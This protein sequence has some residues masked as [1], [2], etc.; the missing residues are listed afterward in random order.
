MKELIQ[1]YRGFLGLDV[2]LKGYIDLDLCLKTAQKHSL[3]PILLE[4]TSKSESKDS[5]LELSKYMARHAMMLQEFR[6]ISDFLVE[7]NIESLFFKGVVLGA[8]IYSNPV[9]RPCRDIDVLIKPSDRKRVLQIF[10]EKGYVP[11]EAYSQSELK[12]ELFSQPALEFYHV[13]RKILVDIHWSIGRSLY[14]Q[15]LDTKELFS[16]SRE[17]ELYDRKV[18]TLSKED[19]LIALA[20]N[21]SRDNWQKLNFVGDFYLYMQKHPLINFEKVLSFTKTNKV[22]RVFLISVDFVRKVLQIPFL[23]M[24]STT[25]ESQYIAADVFSKFFESHDYSEVDELKLEISIRETVSAKLKNIFSRVFLPHDRDFK[26]RIPDSLFF[27][28]FLLKPIKTLSRAVRV[29]FGKDK[30]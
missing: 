20:L 19:T 8:E 7:E 22:N 12:L 1:A 13:E 27:L 14:G 6:I 9:L 18:K 24:V 29:G 23:S 21:A 11:K 16:R 26:T 25:K 17:I 3:T 28:H 5:Q 30:L 10:K 15:S 2:G 4:I